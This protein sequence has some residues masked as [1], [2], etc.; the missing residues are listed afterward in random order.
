V[1]PLRRWYDRSGGRGKWANGPGEF[2]SPD[3]GGQAVE[4]KVCPPWDG[5]PLRGSEPPTFARPEILVGSSQ[6]SPFAVATMSVCP[7]WS[8]ISG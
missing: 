5:L 2:F 7:S 8:A 6:H 3:G 4:N 1:L